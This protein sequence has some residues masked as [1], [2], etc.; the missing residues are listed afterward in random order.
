M[1]A[2]KSFSELGHLVREKIK[3]SGAV[4]TVVVGPK[5]LKYLE[6]AVRAARE[7]LINPV[8]IGHKKNIE[9][10]AASNH[11]D[12]GTFKIIDSSSPLTEAIAMA[13]KGETKLIIGGMAPR[14]IAV[15]IFKN[16]G[17]FVKAGMSPTHIALMQTPRYH[18]MMF[19]SDAAVFG[20]P[21]SAQKI[22]II[23]NAAA[24][25]RTLGVSVPKVTLLAAVEA[26]Y[27]AVPV[28]MEEA[29]I[30]KMA[31][32]GQIKNVLV[33]GPLSFDVSISTEVAQQKGIKN[34]PVAGDPDIFVGPSMETSYGIYQAMVLYAKAE[35]G[36][37]IYGCK[38]PIATSFVSDNIGNVYNSILL[39]L[40]LI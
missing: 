11:I 19:L 40:H 31:D 34:S 33:D 36:S 5:E 10:L 14:E 18:K 2:I 39:G 22:T 1:S 3:S 21:D 32:R 9:D 24:L 20:N 12:I 28:T 27:P 35:A 26:I 6:A 30:A 16:G 13:E 8:F 7:G 29:A 4:P 37:V 25:V 17:G 15:Q 38:V 23:E